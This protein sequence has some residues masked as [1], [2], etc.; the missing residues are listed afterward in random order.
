M[1]D[2]P[3]QIG[4]PRRVGNIQQS[5]ERAPHPAAPRRAA[6]PAFIAGG[7]WTQRAN[8]P[9]LGAIHRSPTR[10][11]ASQMDEEQT[12]ELIGSPDEPATMVEQPND[13]DDLEGVDDEDEYFGDYLDD[14]IEGM[15]EEYD[16][17]QEDH[18]DLAGSDDLHESSFDPAALGLKEIN[19]LAHFGVSSHKPGNGVVELLSDDPDR[20]W[21]SDGQ[22]P[23]LLTI[24]F[25][26]RVEIRA[27]RFYV[28]YTQD[29]SYTPTNIVFYAGTSQHDLLQFAEM[30]LTNP[31]GW[32]DVPVA[33]CGGGHDGNSLSCFV[34]QMLVK[35]NH[36][37]G[38]DTHIRGIKIYALDENAVGG[39]YTTVYEPEQPRLSIADRTTGAAT[40][41]DEEQHEEVFDPE[42]AA[43]LTLGS[44][45]KKAL[46]ELLGLF[47][48]NPLS[49]SG[50]G[51]GTFSNFPDFMRDPE[52]R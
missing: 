22:Q 19:N 18:D 37:N 43:L 28:D 3:E 2:T 25:L 24:H 13:D 27:I 5:M 1:A 47:D 52:I 34:V 8:P 21:Q 7:G 11:V 20:Y 45:R 35:E 40:V 17:D 50:D 14:E 12:S 49:G 38:K 41:I 46:Q 48:R 30:P 33:G 23:H 42:I 39:P 31:V 4:G 26:R 32:Q 29:E 15:A 10:E 9:P 51:D 16:H 6:R 36:Q 44:E